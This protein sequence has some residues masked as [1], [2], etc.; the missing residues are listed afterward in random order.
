MKFTLNG[1][2]KEYDGN[3]NIS[4]L[5]Y[6]RENQHIISPKDGCS[7]QGTCGSCTVELNK[8][9]VLSCSVKMSKVSDGY[10][11]TTEGMDTLINAAFI[12]A[13]TEKGGVQCGFCIPGIVMRAKILLQDNPNPSR[14]EIAYA[15]H[16][17]LCRCTGYVKIID[18]IEYVAELI[19]QRNFDPDSSS[20]GKIGTNQPKYRLQEIITGHLPYV[21]D[22]NSD[23]MYYAALKFGDYPRAKILKIDT[24]QAEKLNGVIKICTAKDVPGKRHV[25]LIISDWPIMIDEG[26]TTHYIGDVIAGVVAESADI[27]HR[28]VQMINVDY[29]VLEPVTDVFKAMEWG[30]PQVHAGRD[31]VLEKCI[32]KRSNI[33]EA[34]QKSE[35]IIHRIFKTQTVEHGFLEPEACI[36][37]PWKDGIEI[38]TQSQGVYEDQR[39]IAQLLGL[40]EDKVNVRQFHTGGGFGGKED[41]SVQGQTALFSYLVK[42]PVKLVLSRPESI[43]IHPKRHP[44]YLDYTLG[45]DRNGKLTG[46]KARIIGDT[47][48]YASVGMK[49]LERAAGHCTGAYMV[50][51]VDTISTAV[52]SNNIPNG[53]MRGF[54]VNQVNFAMEACIDELC[55]LGNFDRWQ[56]RYDNALTEG[57]LTATGQKLEGG[58]GIR[59]TLLAVQEYFRQAEYA[60]LACGMKNTGI[61]NG[62][63]DASTAKVVIRSKDS[64]TIHH[65]W[66]EMGQGINTMAVQTL[67]QETGIDPGIVTVEVQTKDDTPAGMTTAS[68]ATSLLGNAIIDACKQLKRDLDGRSLSELVGN[69]YQGSW[70]C[71]WTTKPGEVGKD[72]VTHYSYSYAT[73]LVVLDKNGKI[74]RVYAA[75]DAGKIMNPLLFEGQ[76]EGSIHM[77]LGYALSEIFEY[78]NC[79]P[80]SYKLSECGILRAKDMPKITV[81]GI[82]LEDPLGPYGAKGVGEIG[83]V[84]TAPAVA[85]ALYQFD[86][87]RRY[88]LPMPN[89]Q[90]K[91]K[92]K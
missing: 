74:D 27:A 9:A 64:V 90:K 29:E 85:N 40:A 33:E 52:Y 59:E 3:P 31:N 4:L 75:H 25:G 79:I 28:A 19:G 1:I 67:C 80:R 78:D 83:L 14:K 7:G 76:I 8:K 58:V 68:R 69:Q 84:P 37:R 35:F 62:M 87:Q 89:Y 61:G 15:L 54:G 17:H 73:Q 20:S 65:G 23:E 39:Q 60:G 22:L 51:A 81:I 6:L 46:L 34:L 16:K 21:A 24:E 53:A 12:K 77:G 30:T 82:E 49:V 38:F 18:A 5:Q 10:I 42:R 45:C 2:V 50:P 26:E 13:F 63:I 41:L 57:A 11:I 47:G 92:I 55:E 70:I 43:R 91:Q 32:I 44:M 88:S 72:V 86:H 56:F 71:D 66:C 48:A 36:A